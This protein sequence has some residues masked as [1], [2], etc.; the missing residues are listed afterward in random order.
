MI[1]YKSMLMIQIVHPYTLD[2]SDPCWYDVTSINVLISKWSS[3][4][5]NALGKADRLISEHQLYKAL[6]DDVQQR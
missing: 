6:G 5:H 1:V 3:Y 2:T 4:A